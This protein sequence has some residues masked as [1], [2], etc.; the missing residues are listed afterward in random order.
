MKKFTCL[1]LVALLLMV[2]PISFAQD[3]TQ[4]AIQEDDESYMSPDNYEYI[5]SILKYHE[6]MIDGIVKKSSAMGMKAA[7]KFNR[8]MYSGIMKR[9]AYYAEFGEEAYIDQYRH[10]NEITLE[11]VRERIVEIYAR[12][13]DETTLDEL[14]EYIRIAL[15]IYDRMGFLD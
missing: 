11:Q 8:A 2:Y 10:R 14:N 12:Y 7:W 15:E 5:Y 13:G 6:D 4:N 9:V 1:T 3:L